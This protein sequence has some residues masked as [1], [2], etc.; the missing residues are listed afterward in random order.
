M[1][2][3]L[4][5]VV[6]PNMKEFGKL[7]EDNLKVI[8]NSKEGFI[9]DVNL[10][11]F[12]NG[13]GK[14]TM[15]SSIRGQNVFLLSDVGHYGKSSEYKSRGKTY[16]KSPDDHFQDIKRTISAM[17]GREKSLYVVT[18]LLYESRQDKRTSGMLG[19]HTYESLDCKDAIHEL[20]ARNVNGIITYDVHNHV[21]CENALYNT[22]FDN[23][24]PTYYILRKFLQDLDFNP[25]KLLVVA[26]DKGAMDRARFYANC[27]TTNAAFFDKRR[28]YSV[29]VNGKNP[30]IEHTFSGGDITGM[31]IM[32]VDD[33]IASGGSILEVAHELKKR[34]ANRVFLNATFPLF[35][36][37][38]KSVNKFD[39]AYENGDFYKLYTTNV[40]YVPDYIKEK[41]WYTEV[42]MSEYTAKVIDKIERG[43]SIKELSD[44][45][46]RIADK[47]KVLKKD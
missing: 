46:N 10:E 39:K 30:I 24:Y 13:E 45:R 41:P 16:L 27:L 47:M 5:L 12:A 35:S 22:S 1:S 21:A 29:V 7:V 25:N 11:R 2:N 8:R 19:K 42:D 15:D 40:T 32:V 17:D 26:P 9:I 37:G 33:I 14:A 43:E 3:S 44:G 34:R 20:E 31:D 23:L 4:K 36:D 18:P 28:D 6:M 38:K